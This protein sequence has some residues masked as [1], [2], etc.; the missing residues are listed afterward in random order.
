MQKVYCVV[1]DFCFVVF[2]VITVLC[3]I[4]DFEERFY[5]VGTH[6]ILIQRQYWFIID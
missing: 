5:A 6:V 4:G 2:R 1:A 3:K